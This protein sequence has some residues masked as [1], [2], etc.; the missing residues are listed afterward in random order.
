L[1][2]PR[3]KEA[4]IALAVMYEIRAWNRTDESDNDHFRAHA[5]HAR[6]LRLACGDTPEGAHAH[7]YAAKGNS[8]WQETPPA[9][10]LPPHLR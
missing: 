8:L 5:L 4:V 6:T 7:L 2:T 3:E 9:A 1:L 10:D